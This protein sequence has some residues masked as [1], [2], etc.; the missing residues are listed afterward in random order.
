MAG[1]AQGGSVAEQQMGEFL[2]DLLSLETIEMGFNCF[3]THRAETNKVL[4]RHNIVL[5]LISLL[6]FV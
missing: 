4:I 5:F 6:Y 1:G 2:Q 3:L